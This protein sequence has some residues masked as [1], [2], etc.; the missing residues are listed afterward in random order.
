LE[1]LQ[2]PIEKYH[3]VGTV[4]KS[5]RKIIETETKLMLLAHVYMT[6]NAHIHDP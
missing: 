5:N 3:T 2:N 6:P 1:Q 4:P